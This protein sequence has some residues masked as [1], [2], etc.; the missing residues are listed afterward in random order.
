MWCQQTHLINKQIGNNKKAS[1]RGVQ[2]T[3]LK[4]IN[5]INTIAF[6]M[7]KKMIK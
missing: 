7:I 2:N 3:R 5:P 1:M 4:V 6:S